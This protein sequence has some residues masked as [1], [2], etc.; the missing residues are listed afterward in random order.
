MF[1]DHFKMWYVYVYVPG[2]GIN[3]CKHFQI[4]LRAYYT[5]LRISINRSRTKL[6][7][8]QCQTDTNLWLW[9]IHLKSIFFY[10]KLQIDWSQPKTFSSK[11]SFVSMVKMQL[12]YNLIK[13]SFICICCNTCITFESNI[14]K[15]KNSLEKAA[16][17]KANN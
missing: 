14:N 16:Q 9:R 12:F 11:L 4:I 17:V 15:T 6:H 13:I 3:F 7:I 2:R 1:I 10:R 5:I 8:F